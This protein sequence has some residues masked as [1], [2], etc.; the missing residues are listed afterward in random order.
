MTTVLFTAVTVVRERGDQRPRRWGST[1][2]NRVRAHFWEMPFRALQMRRMWRYAHPRSALLLSIALVQADPTQLV[3][4]VL[5]LDPRIDLGAETRS[6]LLYCDCSLRT[7]AA[8][9]LDFAPA[10]SVTRPTG[11]TLSIGP[12]D[13]DLAALVFIAANLCLGLLISTL[14]QSQFQAMQMT[15]FFLP[16][17]LLSGFM[18]PF[19]GMPRPETDMSYPQWKRPRNMVSTTS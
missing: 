10:T 14:T 7:E 9:T 19:D 15:F 16:S 17:I 4:M 6:L 3:L 18:F 13:L 12:L 1:S 8:A 2:A 5:R 11:R